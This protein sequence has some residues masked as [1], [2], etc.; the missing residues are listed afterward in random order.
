MTNEDL[1]FTPAAELAALIRARKL[2]P[3]ELTDIVL[4]RLHALEPKLNAFITIT[5][6]Q[7]R[8]DARRAEQAVM[9]GETLGP[10]HG[11]P[12]GLKDFIET[13]GV[14]TTFGSH[15]MGTSKNS[16]FSGV[17]DLESG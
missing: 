13:K 5:D 14:R 6:D 7:A 11:V 15:L 9:D 12:M 1:C 8:I 4:D 16:P 10:L 2:S 3:V 17:V